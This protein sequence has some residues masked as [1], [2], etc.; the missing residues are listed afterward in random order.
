MGRNQTILGEYQDIFGNLT[1]QTWEPIKTHLGAYQDTYG[2]STGQIWEG[3]KT[4]LGRL[5]QSTE[6][7]GKKRS[8]QKLFLSEF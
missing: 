6:S 3:I 5:P 8:R 4:N 1:G 7:T 2:S